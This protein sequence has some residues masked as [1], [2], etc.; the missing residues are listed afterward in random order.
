[1]K[2]GKLV[3]VW[4][5]VAAATAGLAD[6]NDRL[7]PGM[8]IDMR[9]GSCA[10]LVVEAANRPSKRVQALSCNPEPAEPDTTTAIG[11]KTM[12]CGIVKFARIDNP[13]STDRYKCAEGCDGSFIDKK[14][15][16]TNADRLATPWTRLR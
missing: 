11:V 5:V 14:C 3:Y 1:M 9:G 2:L 10:L 7:P 6:A 16:L 8:Y 13:I 15:A 12:D 4:A